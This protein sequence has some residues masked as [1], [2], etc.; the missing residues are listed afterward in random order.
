MPVSSLQ[1]VYPPPA[2][3]AVEAPWGVAVSEAVCQRF[4]NQTERNT[5]WTSPPTGAICS[6]VADKL[7]WMYDGTAW[8]RIAQLATDVTAPLALKADLAGAT[9]TGAVVTTSTI[10]IRRTGDAPYIEWQ[11]M[12]GTRMGYI[13]AN[14]AGNE[15]LYALDASTDRHRFAV[16]GSSRFQ[17]DNSG[18]DVTGNFTV[19]GTAAVNGIFYGVTGRFGGDG[20]QLSLID[21]VSG[22]NDA[23]MNFYGSG[24]TTAPGTHI[25]R[26]GY[27]GSTQLQLQNLAA[28]GSIRL[29]TTG[30][31]DIIFQGGVGG[32]I[33]FTPNNTFQGKMAGTV[34]MW[35][36]AASDLTNAGVEMYG[37]G[38]GAEGAVRATV[39]S[40]SI[41]NLYLRHVSSANANAAPYVQFV[42]SAGTAVSTISQDTV[43][44]V[45]VAASAFAA[46]APSDYRLKNVLGPVPDALERLMKLNPVHFAWKANDVE[47][48]GF[49]AH[50]VAEIVPYAVRGEKDAVYSEEEA[51]AAKLAG[52][53]I[54]P[55][56]MKIQNLNEAHLMALVVAAVQEL[57]TRVYKL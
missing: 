11:R 7:L 30:A 2:G 51:E 46:T 18:A 24:T 54:E 32:E 27:V 15:F 13:Q 21:T 49:I 10:A 42:D 14:D 22:G 17:I 12:A 31:G 43:A 1:P 45:G 48:D 6:T 5:R 3:R 29:L 23:Y 28:A 34:F 38:S 19:T 53:K 55:G 4:A 9:F 50:E 16:G 39:A 35:G 26:V 44:P 47:L 36:K 8:V 56:D 41:A 40:A 33:H 25:G 20:A 37:A 52:V 57:T